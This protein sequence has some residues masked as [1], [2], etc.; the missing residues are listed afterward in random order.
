MTRTAR[1]REAPYHTQKPT[2]VRKAIR[3]EKATRLEIEPET[4]RQQESKHVRKIAKAGF[5]SPHSKA[6]K[7]FFHKYEQNQVKS[8]F[9][10]LIK[11]IK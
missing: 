6:N 9:K 10:V 5:L 3:H 11:N 4:K 8:S 7:V 2:K 1:W